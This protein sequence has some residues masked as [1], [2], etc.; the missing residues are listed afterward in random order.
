VNHNSQLEELAS[1]LV[2]EANSMTTE[3]TSMMTLMHVVRVA[4]AI[5]HRA[6]AVSVC[7]GHRNPQGHRVVHGDCLMQVESPRDVAELLWVI[8][9]SM[10]SCALASPILNPIASVL[11]DLRKHIE[12][13]L[14]LAQM[15]TEDTQ[16]LN[17]KGIHEIP[18][19]SRAN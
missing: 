8:V 12:D 10:A 16:V 13:E 1:K 7:K 15:R 2:E 4:A 14:G 19:M 3:E 9:D 11:Y 17:A 5:E 6:L 18:D